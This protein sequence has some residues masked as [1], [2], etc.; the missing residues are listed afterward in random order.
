MTSNNY[1]YCSNGCGQ[2]FKLGN[3]SQTGRKMLLG[4][5]GI[6]HNCPNRPALDKQ[7]S[8]L[9]NYAVT[10]VRASDLRDRELI[11]RSRDQINEI[12]RQ[13]IHFRLEII[14]RPKA[15]PEVRV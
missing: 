11:Q 12:N 14:V 6:P 2:I 10:F 13:L 9:R 7:K 8:E 3:A 5:N 15:K 1:V 4:E